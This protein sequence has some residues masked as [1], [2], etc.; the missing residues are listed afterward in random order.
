[1]VLVITFYTMIVGGNRTRNL[2]A[3]LTTCCGQVKCIQG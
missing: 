1:M 2:D 3:V